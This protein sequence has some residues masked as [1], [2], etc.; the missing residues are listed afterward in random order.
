MLG[1]D[2]LSE[3][4]VV[5]PMPALGAWVVMVL[6]PY[7]KSLRGELCCV[8]TEPGLRPFSGQDSPVGGGRELSR[9]IHKDSHGRSIQKYIYPVLNLCPCVNFQFQLYLIICKIYKEKIRASLVA[10]FDCTQKWIQSNVILGDQRI[11]CMW[12]VVAEVCDWIS[13][14]ISKESRSSRADSTG[15]GG[16][17]G[18]DSSPQL[19]IALYLLS[20]AHI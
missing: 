2:V 14:G 1:V 11:C 13:E 17:G 12:V 15:E 20:P 4:A 18:S 9:Q 6:L 3:G 5:L 19:C 8:E 10:D 7:V 16:I